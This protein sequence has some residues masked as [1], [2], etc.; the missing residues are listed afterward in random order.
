MTD[1]YA[2]KELDELYQLSKKKPYKDKEP[3]EKFLNDDASLSYKKR[4]KIRQHEIS[5]DE[6]EGLREG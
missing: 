6:Y 4:K 3:W 1:F 2:K 5:F